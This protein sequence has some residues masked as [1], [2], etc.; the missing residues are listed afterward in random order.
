MGLMDKIKNMFTEEEEIEEEPIK[1][2]VIQVEIPSPMSK[3]QE[4]VEEKKE[5]IVKEEPKEEVQKPKPAHQPVQKK[6]EDKFIFPVYFD[7]DDFSKLEK[8]QEEEK[9]H[10]EEVKTAEV[11]RFRESEEKKVIK[12]ISES[13]KGKAVQVEEKKTF[14]PTPIISPVYGILDKN[15]TKED[16]TVKTL[17]QPKKTPTVDIVRNKAYGSL[18]DEIVDSLDYEVTKKEHTNS[19]MEEYRKKMDEV[20]FN[21]MLENDSLDDN[22]DELETKLTKKTKTTEPKT[23]EPKYSRTARKKELEAQEINEDDLFDMIDTMYEED[24]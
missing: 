12:P 22:L 3:K 20:D 16:I 17:E 2:E 15:Y 18:E 19:D 10:R 24:K 21:E 1:K 9:K 6:Q 11:R 5:E 7:D 23:V 13:Y 14:K 8:K 4:K